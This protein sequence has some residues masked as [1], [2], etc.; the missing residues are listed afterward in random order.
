MKTLL[1]IVVIGLCGGCARFST[2]Q[3]EIRNDNETMITTKATAY[4]L[5]QGKSALA[6]W[7]AEQ[8]EGVQGAE[9]GSLSQETSAGTNVVLALENILKIVESVK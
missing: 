2:R 4:T 7:K 3:V 6:N 9:V 1:L 8:S 5:F